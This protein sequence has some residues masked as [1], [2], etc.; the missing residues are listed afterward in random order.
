MICRWTCGVVAESS[1]QTLFKLVIS[2]EL[3]FLMDRQRNGSMDLFWQRH[4]F[5]LAYFQG[6]CATSELCLI[7][8]QDLYGRNETL[9]GYHG[10]DCLIPAF[11]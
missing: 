7:D 5:S 9:R 10:Q 1:L 8:M 11:P 2:P 4:A 3:L 6:A